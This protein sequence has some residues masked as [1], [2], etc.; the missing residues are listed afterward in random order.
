MIVGQFQK[1]QLALQTMWAYTNSIKYL[2]Y[3]KYW[4]IDF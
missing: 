2:Y 3:E 4:K 1:S